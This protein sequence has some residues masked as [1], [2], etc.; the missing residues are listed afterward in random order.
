MR[1]FLYCSAC[2]FW[3]VLASHFFS[4]S[5]RGFFFSHDYLRPISILHPRVNKKCP[6]WRK[7]LRVHTKEHK[8]QCCCIVCVVTCDLFKVALIPLSA[9][10]VPTPYHLEDYFFGVNWKRLIGRFQHG[11][12]YYFVVD[13]SRLQPFEHFTVHRA[14]IVRILVHL[15]GLKILQAFSM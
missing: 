11:T 6:N 5:D 2:L 14:I 1:N 12:V 8:R 15:Q 13:S 9:A 4:L 3:F 7:N 10:I